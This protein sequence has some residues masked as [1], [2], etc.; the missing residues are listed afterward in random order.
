MSR[1][2]QGPSF[3]TREPVDFVIVGSG[4][5]GG[6]MAKELSTAGFDV[7]VLEQGPYRR[8]EDFK[9]DAYGIWMQGDLSH[10]PRDFPTSYRETPADESQPVTS[11]F[12]SVVYSP[13]V[14]GSS[15][16]FTGNYWRMRPSDFEERSRLGP[17]SGTGF[18]DWPITYEELEPY[19]T[20]V[21]W[22][23][24]V[25]GAPGPGDPPRSRGFPVPPL[26]VKSS[27]VL[28]EK[29]AKAM[30]WTSQHAPMAILSQAHNGRSGC[31]HCG[32][33]IGHGCEA[34]AKSSTL[35]SMIPVAEAT[36]RCE[37]RPLST[38]VRLET[39]DA[40]RVTE[41][42]YHDA[43]GVQQAQQARAVVLCANGAE[44]TRLLMMSE[45]TRSP[46]GLANSSGALGRYLMF[47]GNATV[48][49]LFEHQLNEY[50]SVQVTRLVMDFYE[51][52]PQRGFYGGGALDGRTGIGPLGFALFGLPPD[53]PQWGPDF[54]NMVSEYFTRT[55]DVFC[56]GTS[57]PQEANS[58]TM[59]DSQTDAF[60][61]P[62]LRVTY[63]DHPDDLAIVRWLQ[64]RAVELLDAAGARKTWH[65]P[66][67]VQNVGFHLLGTARMGDD[68][69]ASVVDRY[70]RTHDV[71]NLFICD[72][73]SMVSSTRGQPTMTIQALAFRAAEHIAGFAHRNEI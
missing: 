24:G 52:D 35:A 27:G 5:A 55:M 69:G 63:Q 28:L 33:C 72:G 46:E 65:F 15:V 53:A 57:L 38:V 36:G 9:H 60:G 50:K 64:E 44:T 20:K 17:I 21:E 51:S 11:G 54:K 47:N 40:G 30:G 2:Q 32:W 39:N 10:N 29:G 70:H 45:A 37:I 31:I 25:S 3:P 71:P 23:V 62:G 13:G 61:R 4:A 73:S 67:Q 34:N 8:A 19:Y 14:G 26:P 41:V 22:E 43:E 16:H 42:V 7:V 18:V 12:P 59:D 6:V 68:P 48:T 56:H 66:A 58:I 1:A 49:G